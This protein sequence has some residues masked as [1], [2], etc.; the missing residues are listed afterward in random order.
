MSDSALT[1][2][3]LLSGAGIDAREAR[4][5]LAHASGTGIAL[6]AAFPERGISLP[7]AQRFLDMAQ[8]RRNGEPIAYVLGMR[9][10]YSREFAVSPATLIPRPET[11]LLVEQALAHIDRKRPGTRVLDLGTGSGAVAV[12]I[13]CEAPLA[14]VTAVDISAA[15]LAVARD[16]AQRLCPGNPVHFE[17]GDWYAPIGNARYEL[18]A[19]NPPYIAEADP[20]LGQGDLRYE[21]RNALASGAQGLDAIARI[22]AEAPAHLQP[23]AWVLLEHGYDQAAAVRQLLE[24][25]GLEEAQ[26]WRDLA[27]IERVSGA[28]APR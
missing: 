24:S 2:A 28:R 10:F 9:E 27:G 25:A 1:V 5:L 16:N 4:L 26:S 11:E 3:E 18:I 19:A 13:A 23:G 6:L 15:A 8:R 14:R 7:T 17:L 21:P 12:T 22:V 20:H